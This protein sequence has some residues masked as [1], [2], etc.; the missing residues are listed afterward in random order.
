MLEVQAL[1]FKCDKKE[2]VH[3]QN[4]VLTGRPSEPAANEQKWIVNG[5]PLTSSVMP[6]SAGFG[7]FGTV[8]G[9]YRLAGDGSWTGLWWQARNE[10]Q[11]YGSHVHLAGMANGVAIGVSSM[12]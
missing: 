6:C 9:C 1:L 10:C 4:F 8:S 12:Q 3:L 5:N 11:G 7:R 2:R